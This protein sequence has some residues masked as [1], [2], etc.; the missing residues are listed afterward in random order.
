MNTNSTI[1]KIYKNRTQTLSQNNFINDLNPVQD[2]Y[3]RQIKRK[4]ES[5]SNMG[6]LTS[7][8]TANNPINIANLASSNGGLNS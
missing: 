3:Y 7:N 4:S 5:T 2:S 6:I 1:N 8:N